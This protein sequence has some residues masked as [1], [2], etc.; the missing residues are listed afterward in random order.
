MSR[1]SQRYRKTYS[2]YRV[3]PRT[4]L[5]EVIVDETLDWKKSVRVAS[6][7]NVSLSGSTPLSIDGVSLVDEDRVLLKDQDAGSENGIYYYEVSG[8]NYTLTRSSDA[9][10]GTISC[11][12]S[13]YVEEGTSGSGKVFIMS[14][15]GEI[16]VDT[17]SLAWTQFAGGGGGGLGGSGTSGFVSKFTAAGTLGNSII[18][19]DGTNVGIGASPSSRL[20]VTGSSSSSTPVAIIKGGVLSPTD[21]AA[22]LD[23]Q[24]SAGTSILF[25]TGTLATIGGRVGIGTNRPSALFHVSGT[26]AGSSFGIKVGE[27]NDFGVAT[28]TYT[29]LQHAFYGGDGTTQRLIIDSNGNILAGGNLGFVANTARFLVSGSS[30]ATDQG[31]VYKAGV[32]SPTGPLLDIM[33]YTGKSIV[34]VS[35]SGLSGSLTR[36]TDGT[37]Y[38]IAGSNVTLT[39]GSNG[40]V[41]I[42]STAGGG[43]IGGSGT[44]TYIPKFTPDGSTLGNSMLS[45]SGTT[46]TSTAST[47]SFSNNQ[48]WKVPANNSFA[49]QIQDSASSVILQAFTNASSTEKYVGI[50]TSPQAPL[51]VAHFGS[52][53]TSD[54]F[55]NASARTIMMQNTSGTDGNSATLINFNNSNQPNGYVRFI[56]TD[57]TLY[58][59]ALAFGTSNGVSDRGE[60]MRINEVGNVGIGTTSVSEKLSVHNGG[61]DRVGFGITSA[62]ST[63]YLG[64]T[65]NTEA[66][67]TIEFDRSVGKLYFKYGNVGSALTTVATFNSSG[68]VGIGNT[69]PATKLFVESPTGVQIEASDGTVNQ[70]V[71]Y[72]LNSVAY[73][74]TS[75]GHPYALLTTDVERMRIDTTGNVG[76]GTS[77]TGGESLRVYRSSG[78]AV[79]VYSN[80]SNATIIASGYNSTSPVTAALEVASTNATIGTATNHPFRIVTNSSEALRVSTAGNV[81]IGTSAYTGRFYVHG[82]STATTPTAVIREGVANPLAGVGTFDV[83]N[84]SGT[85]IMFVSGSG[86]VGL[87]TT[88]PTQR[89]QLGSIVDIGSST[90]T[91]TPDSITLGSTYSNTPGFSH[92]LR[93]WETTVSGVPAYSGL[94]ISAFSQDYSI[95]AGWSHT[96]Y[97]GGSENI[98]FD[99]SGNVGIGTTNPSSNAESL[100]VYRTSSQ[101]AVGVYSDTAKSSLTLTGYKNTTPVTVGLSSTST[102]GAVGTATNHPLVLVTNN[103]ERMRIET[104]SS[105]KIGI[106]TTTPAAGIDLVG[107]T[108][109]PSF[110]PTIRLRNSVGVGTAYVQYGD[111][112]TSTNNWHVGSEG[113]GSFRFYNGNY[114]S[115]TEVFRTDNSGL[116][117]TQSILPKA[118]NTYSLGSYGFF[119]YAWSAVFS[120]SYPSVSDYRIKKNVTPL[121]S[122]LER[123][124]SL[125]PV[126][127]EYTD[128]VSNSE[129]LGTRVG[130]V[131]HELQEIFPNLASGQKDATAEDGKIVPQT[132]F[133]DDLIPYIVNAIKELK[134][135]NDALKA[136]IENLKAQAVKS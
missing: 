64:S 83:Q 29:S 80:T 74:G 38:L 37:P 33:D 115:G 109:T 26:Y 50:G 113:D 134:I 41:T 91:A 40:A 122:S 17:T 92:K 1:D 126:S 97:V 7:S 56:N 3:Q 98:R 133:Q 30:T 99:S 20:Y 103:V 84:F 44:A 31:F 117:W 120:W 49:L 116:L 35:G 65:T 93:L 106:G 90:A 100:T 119:N 102:V 131:A 45:E 81:G 42:S 28:S 111:H 69:S 79:G 6:T 22:L 114:G 58:K 12:A 76:I 130:F 11:G 51:H 121:S 47:L 34:F 127:Y 32:A 8:G 57:N 95:P 25:V 112:A 59:G 101:S 72:C 88:N 24:N 55:A 9:R 132:I 13:V 67:R 53:T 94:G 86:N 124:T 125:N 66:Y 61:Q 85:S 2:Y 46:I 68:Q 10:T 63:I 52:S 48:V 54:G 123:L 96:F 136:E 21:N 78:N 129:S 5:L 23:V 15:T 82:S 60:R 19:D 18:R 75:T 107:G 135:E 108:T 14:T 4:E 27:P 43:G 104:S 73:S 128:Y 70:R 118:D 16:V 89:L 77:S 39:T 71:G 62:V 87:G 36:L 105:V 110:S